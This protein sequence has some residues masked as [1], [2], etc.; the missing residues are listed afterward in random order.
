[1][2]LVERFVHV[3]TADTPAGYQRRVRALAATYLLLDLLCL[4]TIVVVAMRL[5]VLVTLAQRSNVET[6]TLLVLVALAVQYLATTARGG[7]G[8]LRI[9][10]YAVGRRLGDATA[11]A[12]RQHDALRP[13]DDPRVVWLD[14]VVTRVEAP[15]EDLSWEVGD[16]VGKLGDLH[17][18]GEEL[19]YD[20]RRGMLGNTFF[21]FVAA[22]IL[23]RVRERTP[24][25]TLR[26]V[27]WKSIDEDAGATWHAQVRA[28]QN[29]QQRLGT[30]P[31]WPTVALTAD[32][33]AEVQRT[34]REL[35]PALRE[36]ALLPDV[37]YEVEYRVPVLPEPLAF[38]QL[39]RRETRADP[40]AT[41]G[42]ATLVMA[43]ALVV[44][45]LLITWPP[46]VPSR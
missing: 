12:R 11:W 16:A 32:D 30:G 39:S 44:L 1:L 38:V 46:W 23:D 20:P 45:A 3:T 31:I 35:C 43:A 10:G 5:K 8:A 41:M 24:D 14:K 6:L 17:L 34:I 21:A 2:P 15:G 4:A 26:I 19:R 33:H 25:A 40:V 7:V 42:C 28:F 29:L 13:S 22:R 36:E 27:R 9:V 18:R 37:E